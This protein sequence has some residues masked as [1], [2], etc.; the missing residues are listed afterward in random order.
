MG[1]AQECGVCVCLCVCVC[2]CVC[3]VCVSVQECNPAGCS[4]VTKSHGPAV[5]KIDAEMQNQRQRGCNQA[6]AACPCTSNQEWWP[7]SVGRKKEVAVVKNNES[8]SV[9]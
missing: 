5:L 2:V 1:E 4:G 3:G 7:R 8:S 9:I 6:W